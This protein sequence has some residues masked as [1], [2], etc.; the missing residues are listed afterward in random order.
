MFLVVLLFFQS[1][2]SAV[3][4]SVSSDSDFFEITVE[5]NATSE[6]AA[7]NIS[8]LEDSMDSFEV[9][10]PKQTEFNEQMTRSH[11]LEAIELTYDEVNHKVTFNRLN[12][13]TILSAKIILSNLNET[14]NI[15]HVQGN[16]KG[17]MTTLEDYIFSIHNDGAKSNEADQQLEEKQP[18]EEKM[19]KKETSEPNSNNQL[20]SKDEEPAK[21][22][23]LQEEEKEET[24]SI[25]TARSITL[26][27]GNLN[28]DIDLSPQRSTV[29]SGNTA[30]YHLVLKVTG[31]RTEYTNAEIAID[32]PITEYTDFKQNLSELVID[33]VTP[34]YN[35]STHQLL[36]EFNSIKAGRSY[37]TQIKVNTEN[38]I[39]PHGA[40]LTAQ[41]SFEADNQPEITDDATI[42]VNA[43][44]TVSV[45]KKFKEVRLSGN[46]QKAPFPG[47]FTIWDIK[48]SIPKK[49]VGQMFIK[50]GSKIVI[51]DTFSSGLTF[52]DVMDNSPQPSVSGRTLTWEFD[53]PSIAEQM[54]A[55][56][57]FFT[58]DLRV[59]LQVN[60]NESLVGTTQENNVSVSTTFIDNQTVPTSAKDSI[61]ISSREAAT[62]DVQGSVYV[63]SF[64][65]PSNGNGGFGGNELKDPNPAVYD[66]ALLGFRHGIQSMQEGKQHDF[67]AYTTI[68]NIDSNVIFKEMIT[69]GSWIYAPTTGFYH[70]P[71]TP[72]EIDPAFN[73]VANVNGTERIL[74]KN[75]KSATTYTRADLGLLPADHI[76]YIK[77]DFTYAPTGMY[78]TSLAR[79]YFNVKPGFVGEVENKFDVYGRDYQDQPFRYS[80]DYTQNNTY[81]NLASPRHA[82]IVPRPADQPPIG[83]V[84]I[85]LIDHDGG[86]V[87]RG[88]NRMKVT[89]SNMGSSVLTMSGPLEAVVL[90]PTGV[91]LNQMPKASYTNSDGR[92]SDGQYEVLDSNYNGTGRQL[93]KI[94]WNDDRI[95]IGRNLTAELDVL[96]SDSAP[97][98]L[99]F[100]VYGFSGDNELRAPV[101]SGGTITDTLLQTDEDDLNGDSLTDQPRLK[102]G[103]IY[104]IRGKYDIQTEK[105]VKGELD[106]EFTYFGHTTPNGFIDYQVKL[107]N[108][109]GQD[110]SKFTLIDVL[111]S[112]G[113][114]GITDNIDRGSKFT[115]KMTNSVILPAEWQDKVNV[116]YSTA[117]N[118][119]RN[120][121]TKNTVYPDTTT[122]LTNPAGAVVPNW[123]TESQVT[124]WPTIHSF[125]IE[126]K[127]GV[128]WV[129]G[130]D[131]MI[132]FSMQAPSELEVDREV[133]DAAVEP[134]ERAAWNSFAVATDH[135]QPV[136]PL[137]VGVYMDYEVEDPTVEKNVNDSKEPVELINRDESFTWKVEYDFGNYTGN[138]ESV[139]LSDQI[140][141]LLDIEHV[142]VIDQAGQDVVGNGTLDDTGNL[143]K[144]AINKKDGSFAY[145]KNQ[146]Y[147]LIIKSKIKSTA[148]DEELEPFIQTG[149]IPNTAE[150]IINNDPQQSNEVK[151]KPPVLGDIQIVKIDK[152]TREVLQ[153]AEFELRK[154]LTGDSSLQDCEVV[155]TGTTDVSGEL[156]FKGHVKGHYKLLETKAPEGYRLL[157]KPIDVEITDTERVIKL[158]VENNKSGWELPDTGGIGTSIFYL[159]GALLMASALF[160][161]FKRKKENEY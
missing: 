138:W 17:E 125:K 77:L 19:G 159:I 48:V 156:A 76:S 151:V 108:T 157:T 11:I 150:L 141:E 65:G 160:F 115:P 22:E 52:Y 37:E 99:Q 98:S 136:E 44:N 55:D 155:A 100:D 127:D 10:L 94:K 106:N 130:Q 2:L 112:V 149:G 122:K 93:V 60:N 67:N 69:P 51:R 152:E 97:N 16:I 87:I 143:V 153:G 8:A 7:I 5:P 1:G 58:M 9:L 124:D 117:K 107:T 42:T 119:E 148:T 49:D 123:M 71:F 64:Y 85:E 84:A 103:N 110:I 40:E 88:D 31:S 21:D 81:L 68:V 140:H 126:L 114:L 104:A 25:H 33:G 139:V 79:Y 35:E 45:T 137:R 129:K 86:E 96:I 111:P 109:T 91:M 74:V 18:E 116:F 80:Q 36:Y 134:A 13:Q 43:S 95:R 72:L 12:D 131:M 30:G 24:A 41:A 90:L 120:D 61:Y 82:T 128:D 154:C 53:A 63:P 4:I 23:P 121:L 83:K 54:T 161:V 39:S 101:T 133:L 145:L 46:V 20:E 142:Q 147:T 135:G 92:A 146:K 144:F 62:G 27:S 158:E 70:S 14:N 66:D 102:S 56:G 78:S 32:L 113:D 38:G 6:L 132:Q 15:L 57:E 105:L 50:E 89:L 28:V 75:A 59:R 73:I 34:V 3:G 118:P 29:L 26:F 47:S